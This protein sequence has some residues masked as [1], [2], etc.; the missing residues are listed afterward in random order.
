MLKPSPDFS[1]L[2]ECLGVCMLVCETLILRVTPC[3][4]APTTPRNAVPDIIE[5]LCNRIILYS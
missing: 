4:V 5:K 1:V 2:K 3:I